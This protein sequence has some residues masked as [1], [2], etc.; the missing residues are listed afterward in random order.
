MADEFD[1]EAQMEN[2]LVYSSSADMKKRKGHVTKGICTSGVNS[3]I[4]P[5]IRL[6]NILNPAIEESARTLTS[7]LGIVLMVLVLA[8]LGVIFCL[9]IET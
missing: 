8:S 6:G 3:K 9:V 7:T 4:K 5:D 2:A 1:L